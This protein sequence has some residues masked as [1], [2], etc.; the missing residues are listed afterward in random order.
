VKL[1]KISHVLRTYKIRPQ[2]KAAIFGS[3]LL[4]LL[5][6]LVY[7]QETEVVKEH[8]PDVAIEVKQTGTVAAYPYSGRKLFLGVKASF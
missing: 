3:A 2:S 5:S 1:N 4:I 6:S 8:Q 7:S